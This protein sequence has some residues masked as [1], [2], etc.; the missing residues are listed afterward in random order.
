[1][2][3][4]PYE[5][6]NDERYKVGSIITVTCKSLVREGLW[7]YVDVKKHIKVLIKKN[8]LFEKTFQ[9]SR[10][11][12]GSKIDAMIME[13]KPEKSKL[14]LSVKEAESAES[15]AQIK[16]YGARDSGA[17][18]G[19]ILGKALKTKSEKKTKNKK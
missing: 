4:S 5:W 3:P 1:M 7:V 9:Q 8:Q 10:F 12:P 14:I 13:C 16:K 19:D 15:A 2:Q 11:A 18:L 6:L 17:V